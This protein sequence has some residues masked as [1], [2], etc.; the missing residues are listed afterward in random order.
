MAIA[1]GQLFSAAFC[2]AASAT[3][4]ANSRVTAFLSRS[5]PV[6]GGSAWAA[7]LASTAVA[8]ARINAFI[9]L[10]SGG[11]G[12]ARFW[13]CGARVPRLRARV[14]QHALG[15]LLARPD[16]VG[17]ADTAVGAA[18]ERQPRVAGEHPID[19]LDAVQMSDEVLGRRGRMAADAGQDGRRGDPER[20]LELGTRERGERLVVAREHARVERAAQEDAQQGVPGGRPPWI[21]HAREGARQD[22]AP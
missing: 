15:G 4:L 19:R 7:A 8:R 2:S 20:V 11:A 17:D 5:G 1:T 22:R 12:A 21:L 3:F 13:V 14:E 16:A 18:R 10:L 9:C 6:T